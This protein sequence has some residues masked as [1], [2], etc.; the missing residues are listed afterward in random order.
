MSA[1][2]PGALI[3]EGFMMLATV[4]APYIGALLLIGLAIGIFQ[5]ATQINDPA[6]GFMPRLVAGIGLAWML[7]GWTMDRLAHFVT[8]ALHRM[9]ERM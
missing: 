5:A 2:L 6:V 4:G 9:A 8:A 1:E 7:G 3:R